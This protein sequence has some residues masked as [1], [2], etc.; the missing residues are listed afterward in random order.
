MQVLYAF[1]CTAALDLALLSSSSHRFPFTLFV[2]CDIS[3]H[4]VLLTTQSAPCFMSGIDSV[5]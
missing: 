4:R 5:G 3:S 2:C 1:C